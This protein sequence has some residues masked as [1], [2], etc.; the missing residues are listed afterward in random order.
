MQ[1]LSRS[2]PYFLAG[3][4]T[5]FGAAACGDDD[6]DGGGTADS[7][8]AA[9][10]APD[11]DADVV[12]LLRSGTVAVM[13]TSITNTNGAVQGALV[14]MGFADETTRTV[15]PVPGFESSVNGCSITVYN[16]GDDEEP[17]PVGEGTFTV[18]GTSAGPFGCAYVA[19][20]G[21]YMCQSATPAVAGGAAEDATVTGAGGNAQFVLT[22]VSFPDTVVG[23]HI[24]LSGFPPVGEVPVDG[25]YPITGA[26]TAGETTTLTLAGAPFT[27]ASTGDADATYA[28]FVGL[29]PVPGGGVDFLDDGTADLTISKTA[30]DTVGAFEVELNASG[31][32]FTLVNEPE[33]DYYLPHQI[34]T[35]AAAEVKFG[36]EGEGCG[37]EGGGILSA[38][39]ISGT[40]TDGTLPAEGDPA[41]IAMPD[42]VSQYA[43][44]TCSALGADEV[45]IS[46][47]AMEEILGT[48]PTRIQVSVGRVRG[49]IHAADDGSYQTFVLAGHSLLGFTT[50]AAE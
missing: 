4:L 32:G 7:G 25:V 36:C 33:N 37:D 24:Q 22:G 14:R 8:P 27:G 35:D 13:E 41:G 50:V 18:T 1:I 9:D 20:L 23:M 31:E 47:A 11:P 30:G 28:T 39:I 40:T 49:E 29:G 21:Q 17:D 5:A 2:L 46:M 42:P 16:V 44:F 34:P 10:S 48:S 15:A 43:T 26:N 19:A 12:E 6:G 45:A 38:M 3:A